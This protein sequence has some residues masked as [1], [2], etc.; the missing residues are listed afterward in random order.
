MA[1]REA[2]FLFFF[3]SFFLSKARLPNA[4]TNKKWSR[5]L[6][7]YYAWLQVSYYKTIQSIQS[8]NTFT[9]SPNYG[10]MHVIHHTS[11]ST[12]YTSSSTLHTL[13]TTVLYILHAPTTVTIAAELTKNWLEVYGSRPCVKI[14]HVTFMSLPLHYTGRQRNTLHCIW[15]V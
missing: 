15:S 12:L 13:Y 14:I 7:I 2:P 4:Q 10:V 5:R 8:Y 6:R 1:L 9:N 3:F 11:N